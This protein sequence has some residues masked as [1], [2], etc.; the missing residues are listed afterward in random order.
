MDGKRNAWKKVGRERKRGDARERGKRDG[1]QM[2]GIGREGREQTQM[3][4]CI[5]GHG[6][7]IGEGKSERVE[8]EHG[9]REWERMQACEDVD[10]EAGGRE[11]NEGMAGQSEDTW[12]NM[13]RLDESGGGMGRD[14]DQAKARSRV[15]SGAGERRSAEGK[16]SRRN[17]ETQEDRRQRRGGKGDP[18]EDADANA[19]AGLRRITGKQSR[20]TISY[21]LILGASGKAQL[22]LQGKVTVTL[23]YFEEE[24][25]AEGT[26]MRRSGT[27]TL[28]ESDA[29]HARDTQIPLHLL[30]TRKVCTVRGT[31]VSD[32]SNTMRLLKWMSG[33]RRAGASQL[34]LLAHVALRVW[35]AGP[36]GG[37]EVAT[38]IDIVMGKS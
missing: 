12:G 1:R 6:E 35:I 11:R 8:G 19:N 31:F 33:W 21:R 4:G 3:R 2:R 26:Q 23:H 20:Q 32:S 36:W 16:M 29:T 34:D 30:S 24:S 22:K 28:V 27:R 37:G 5:G 10:A 25:L 14:E 9:G 7:G 13:H 18:S 38:D 15:V 17:K